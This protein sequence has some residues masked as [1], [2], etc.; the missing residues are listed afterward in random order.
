MDLEKELSL[1][2]QWLLESTPIQEDEVPLECIEESMNV[3][4]E[5]TS[6]V[7]QEREEKGKKEIG[8]YAYC[9]NGKTKPIRK[10]EP[11]CPTQ[12]Y[13][14]TVSNSYNSVLKCL[15]FSPRELFA[16]TAV[17]SGFQV[18]TLSLSSADIGIGQLTP[19]AVEDIN[20]DW[21]KYLSKIKESNNPYCQQIKAMVS[22]F[23]PVTK[24]LSCSLT[25][26][27]QNPVKNLVYLAFLNFKNKE[28]LDGVFASTGTKAKI[29]ALISRKLTE[30]ELKS[31]K[32][33]LKTLSY[34]AG[35]IG[36]INAINS[37]IEKRIQPL[38]ELHLQL[39]DIE[40]SSVLLY[41]E[42]KELQATG[43][44]N[45]VQTLSQQ[46]EV[47]KG[48]REI[49]KAKINEFSVPVSNF[50]ITEDADSFGSFLKETEVSFYLDVLKNRIHYIEESI[51]K[52]GHCAPQSYLEKIKE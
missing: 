52:P 28:Y 42:I 30:N 47:L 27:P 51:G 6:S 12:S 9:T 18:N 37:Y 48:Q 11:P 8:H 22:D 33:I 41:L 31:I 16:I 2:P 3:F 45:K 21:E 38:E 14:N 29:E 50:A 46:R 43:D 24:N 23:K 36:A 25:Q 15:G 5:W 39:S 4:Y 40:L 35:A 49:I 19:I 20:P 17:E 7:R 13:I 1:Q 44:S 34:N 10:H 26:L 32:S